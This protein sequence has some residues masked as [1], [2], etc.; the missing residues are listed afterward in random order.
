MPDPE[1]ADLPADIEL[2]A[3]EWLARGY[4]DYQRYQ[5]SLRTGDGMQVVQTRDIM[6]GGK[7]VAVLPVDLARG[8]VVLI[9]QFRLAGHLAAGRGD[10]T[11]IVAG[12]VEAG[13]TAAGA[14]RRE[15]KEEIGVVPDGLVELFSFL[16]T[17]GIS[18]ETITLFLASLDA[19]KVPARSGAAEEDER[20]ATI[21]VPI[22]EALAA[23]NRGT[24][25]NGPL[26]IALQWLALNRGR[27]AD[28]LAKG[29]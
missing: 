26:I 10:M 11:E 9:R 21:R 17:P 14:A 18:D 23:L 27:L 19:S 1:L 5:L 7:V 13:E 20:I 6:R 24:M 3:P 15:C 22:D 28:L 16:T 8:E 12:A 2:S 29:V 25:R 4:R